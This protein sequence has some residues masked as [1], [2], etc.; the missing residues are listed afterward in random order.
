VA[1]KTLLAAGSTAL[2]CAVPFVL[3]GGAPTWAMLAAALVARGAA[4]VA[5]SLTWI[6]TPEGYNVEVRATGHS[7]GN[8]L[9]RAGALATTY[10]GGAAVPEPLKVGSYVAVAATMAAVAAAMPEGVMKGSRPERE[11]EAREKARDG[12]EYGAM[13]SS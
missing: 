6:V 9:A 2:A 11:E 1:R 12:G 13:E 7:W 8:L 3:V 5:A 4:N 10:W